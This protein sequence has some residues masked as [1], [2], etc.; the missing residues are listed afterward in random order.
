MKY[1]IFSFSISEAS[2]RI[3]IDA[4][5]GAVLKNISLIQHGKENQSISNSSKQQTTT[6]AETI[7]SS[8]KST[9]VIQPIKSVASS[10]IP[11]TNTTT[12]TTMKTATASSSSVTSNQNLSVGV[13]QP[14]ITMSPSSSSNSITSQRKNTAG[15]GENLLRAKK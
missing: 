15:G 4:A 7:K 14:T 13:N 5:E 10:A 1:T 12:T 11:I 9:K 8:D 3:K 2:R 6:V